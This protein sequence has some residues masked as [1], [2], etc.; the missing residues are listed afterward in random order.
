MT[1]N[2]EVEPLNSSLHQLSQVLPFSMPDSSLS[3]ISDFSLS[4]LC[5]T[6]Q[7]NVSCL[8]SCPA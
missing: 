3:S 4:F 5:A 1:T 8:E 6:L 2:V 7:G